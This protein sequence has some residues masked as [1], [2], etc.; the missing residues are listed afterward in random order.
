MLARRVAAERHHHT[1]ARGVSVTADGGALVSDL[2]LRVATP[3]DAQRVGVLLEASYRVL[4]PE[5]Y[6]AHL[7]ARALP[8]MTRAQP[9]LLASGDYYLVVSSDDT[10][11]GCGGWS[12]G[13]PGTGAL[14]PE[15]AHIRHFATHPSWTRHG[16]GRALFCWSEAAARLAG[17][18]R[19]ECYA[20]LNAEAFY[21][22]LG[23]RRQRTIEVPMSADLRF[24]AILMTRAL[25]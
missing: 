10:A 23:L 1:G 13:R 20:S 24:P 2:R 16:I 8:L 19:L 15:T 7:L 6:D 17:A 4:M 3:D 14:A 11:V 22:R 25:T 5:S 21:A 18:R 9:E 12:L